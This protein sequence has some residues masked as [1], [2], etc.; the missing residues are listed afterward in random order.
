MNRPAAGSAHHQPKS[1][2]AP[3]PDQHRARE[4]GTQGRLGR[5]GLHGM[6]SEHHRQLQLQARQ[7]RHY[8]Q[9]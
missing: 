1:T 7:D 8:H 5:L 3:Q 9:R 2:F 6:G 4:Q